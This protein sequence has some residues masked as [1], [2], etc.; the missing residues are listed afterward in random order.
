M[1]KG[2]LHDGRLPSQIKTLIESGAEFTIA[3]LADQFKV[4][5]KRIS[6]VLTGLRKKG[7]LYYPVGGVYQYPTGNGRP[8][9]VLDVTQNQINLVDT[10]E[11][12]RKVYID[13]QLTSFARFVD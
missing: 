10:M 5:R 8:G 3:E 9:V 11:R 13:P 2:K 1:S 7:F 12:Q 6:S 4:D